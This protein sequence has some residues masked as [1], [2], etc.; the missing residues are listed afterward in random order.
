MNSIKKNIDYIRF[1]KRV[2]KI[3]F[4]IIL[5][6]MIMTLFGMLQSMKNLYIDTLN[7]LN[8]QQQEINDLSSRITNMELLYQ[9][10][11]EQATRGNC[12]RTD[13]FTERYED[14]L[15]KELIE[16]TINTCLEFGVE[17]K[18]VFAIME[19]ESGF[20]PKAQSDTS[21]GLMQINKINA[22]WLENDLGVTDLFNPKENILSGIY[23]LANLNYNTLEEKLMAYNMGVTGASKLWS[24]GI[25][26]TDYTDRV[27]SKML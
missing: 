17:P 4:A 11:N 21:C 13:I 26:S 2:G 14:R 6:I 24:K 15:D 5:A 8:S 3:L 25:Y 20:N 1:Q 9:T 12:D 27:I 23:I 19:T 22:D 16:Y 18:L 7:T 10:E